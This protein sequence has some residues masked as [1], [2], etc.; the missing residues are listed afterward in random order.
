MSYLNFDKGQLVN[1]EYSLNREILRSNRMGAY[2]STTLSGCNTRKYHGLFV[3]PVENFG[4]EKFVLISS[5]DVSVLQNSS[6]F[7]LGIHRYKGGTYE[8]K[9]HKYIDNVEFDQIPKITFRVGGVL[10]VMERLLVENKQQ[11]LIRYT[12]KDTVSPVSLRFK[13]FLAFRNI[14]ELSKSNMFANTKFGRVRNGIKMKLYEQFPELFMQF[15]KEPDFIPAPDWYYDI[16]YLKELTRG[17]EFLEDL[18]VPGYFEVPMKKGESIVFAAGT[19]KSNPISLK[20][21]FT[22]ELNKKSQKFT[23]LALLKNAGEQFVFRKNKS[24]DIIAGFPWYKSITRQTFIALPGLAEALNDNKTFTEV[25]ETYLKYLK[26]GLFPDYIREKEKSYNSAD[27]SLWFV[28]AI[29]KFQ[30]D[31]ELDEIWTKYGWAVKEILDSYRKKQSGF[32][33]MNKD[34]LIY[35]EK[36]YTALTWMNSYSYGKPVI[37]RGGMPVEINALWYNAI[38]FAIE[39]A[40]KAGD[41][42]FVTEWKPIKNKTGRAFL[43]TFWNKEHGHLADVVRNKQQVDWSVRP[44]MVIAAAMDCTP[45]SNEQIKMVL[46][47]TKNKLLTKRG[48]RT[49]SPDHLRYK[50]VIEGNPDEREY[51]IHQGTV[52]PWLMQF[53]AEAYL[54]IHKRGGLPFIKQLIETFEE[55]MT[56]HS[57]GTIS[58][59]YNGNPPHKAKGAISQAWNVAAV[60]YSLNLIHKYSEKNN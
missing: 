20:Q 28:W 8:P 16:E 10:L 15:S 58:E 21:R 43:Q 22:R 11:V 3:C 35:A 13:P 48:L 52:W 59:M 42:Q 56:E 50:G 19:E 1:L 55:E 40:Q 45:L 34:G 26:N 29:Q 14:H 12:L 41:T 23:F 39:E 18:F 38:C 57:I 60:I 6:E 53:F 31:T 37:Q 54:K 49:L 51:A 25:I 4:D 7:N 24:T 47:T 5:L 30:Q 27:S 17:Y 33:G 9:G 2:I 32:W 36:D 44:N 46:S